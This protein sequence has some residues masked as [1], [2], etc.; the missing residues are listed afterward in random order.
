MMHDVS[1]RD[2]EPNAC[3]AF[4][5]AQAP[6]RFWAGGVLYDGERRR[7]LVAVVTDLVLSTHTL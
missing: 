4:F 6:G 7:L 2:D 1:P 5:C 3:V